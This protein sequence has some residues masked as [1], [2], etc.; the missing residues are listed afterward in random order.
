MPACSQC[1]QSGSVC[2]YS[3]PHTKET[4]ARS[5]ISDLENQVARLEAQLGQLQH[6][7]S[8]DGSASLSAAGSAEPEEQQQPVNA[9]AELAHPD[10]IQLE[11]GEDAHYLGASSGKNISTHLAT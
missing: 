4:Q 3:D 6:R 8:H 11:S 9:E 1:Q 2:S 7:K 5:H 10:M